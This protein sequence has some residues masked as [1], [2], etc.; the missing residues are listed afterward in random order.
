MFEL[1]SFP[2]GKATDR[3]TYL[4]P[5]FILMICQGPGAQPE[6]QNWVNF[7]LQFAIV[8]LYIAS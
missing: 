3:V 2:R 7:H 4:V 5:P 1:V 6:S 8:C